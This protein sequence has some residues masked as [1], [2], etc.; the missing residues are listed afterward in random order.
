MQKY[1]EKKHTDPKTNDPIKLKMPRV[2]KH[3]LRNGNFEAKKIAYELSQDKLELYKLKKDLLP[4]L[5]LKFQYSS[6]AVDREEKRTVDI[7]KNRT[8][9]SWEIMFSFSM[10]LE[11]SA[12]KASYSQK[13]TDLIRLNYQMKQKTQGNKIRN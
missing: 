4:D 1:M 12:A 6:A 2:K 10:P 8:F 5:S 9:P 7:I 11:N 13:K 3:Q